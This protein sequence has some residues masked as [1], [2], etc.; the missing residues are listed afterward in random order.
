MNG[1]ERYKDGLAKGNITEIGLPVAIDLIKRKM[2]H[3]V[4]TSLHSVNR[5]ELTNGH[6]HLPIK[7]GWLLK[8][9]DFI[10]GWQCRYFVAYVGRVE[11]YID[12]HD[13]HPKG[14]IDLFGA[15]ISTAFR[16]SVNGVN[17]HWSFS[18]EPRNRERAFRLASEFT[19]EEGMVD[20]TSWVQ[21]FM[22]GAK[23]AES[24][25]G[26]YGTL[27]PPRNVN[28]ISTDG[29]S[30][31]RNSLSMPGKSLRDKERTI[32]KNSDL[33]PTV[34]ILS[35]LSIIIG[36]SVGKGVQ[37]MYSSAST[38][39]ILVI[40]IL[41]TVTCISSS[42]ILGLFDFRWTHLFFNVNNSSSNSSIGGSSSSSGGGGGRA[43]RRPSTTV[44]YVDSNS[45]QAV[46]TTGAE[47]VNRANSTSSK[48]ERGNTPT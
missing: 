26:F 31:S 48:K 37:L 21:A 25:S 47:S 34:I 12:Q 1:G 13:Q 10:F 20:A 32:R 36:L 29:G 6:N 22:V 7:S 38:L 35:T 44:N 40:S 3:S 19:G 45:K 46:T 41:T 9:R 23:P 39:S 8:K 17:D 11:Y 2:F 30:E 24:S 42:F 18:I 27:P 14:V 28:P 33:V 5:T 15:D 43:I 4:D 16:C